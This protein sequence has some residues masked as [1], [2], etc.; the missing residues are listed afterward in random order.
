MNRDISCSNRI[1]LL[2]VLLGFSTL[3][4]CKNTDKTTTSVQRPAQESLLGTWVSQCIAESGGFFIASVTFT[5][6]THSFRSEAFSDPACRTPTIVDDYK[7][8]NTSTYKLGSPVRDPAGAIELDLTAFKAVFTI[9][10]DDF[11]SE[12]NGTDARGRPICGGSFI[13]NVPTEKTAR[14]C[15]GDSAFGYLFDTVHTIYKL[16]GSKLYIGDPSGVEIGKGGNDGSTP[17][18]R[19]KKILNV[20]FT[21]VGGL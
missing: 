1:K 20:P 21:R 6:N 8:D 15:A 11:L 18:Q 9:S 2:G 12:F 5:P 4:G 17:S 13:K 3:H 7:M 19:I 14:D 16:D 10:S